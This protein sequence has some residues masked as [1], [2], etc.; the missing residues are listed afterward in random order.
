MRD[1]NREFHLARTDGQFLLHPYQASKVYEYRH[2]LRQPGEPTYAEWSY[3]QPG[4]KQPLQFTL[5][6]KGDK[7]AIDNIA[8]EFDKHKWSMLRLLIDRLNANTPV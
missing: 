1:T 5:E 8:F 4:D 3:T 7:G 6:L 2:R